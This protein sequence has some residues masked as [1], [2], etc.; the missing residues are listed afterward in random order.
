MNI[1]ELRKYLPSHPAKQ[2]VYGWVNQKKIPYYKGKNG[3]QLSFLKSE[4]DEWMKDGSHKSLDDL[5][6]EA[7][8]FVTRKH[9]PNF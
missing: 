3:K 6:R 1:E 8:A 5:Q 4:I 2:T 9:N 7:V